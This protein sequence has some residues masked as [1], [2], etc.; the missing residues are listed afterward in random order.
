MSGFA[1]SS[2]ERKPVPSAKSHFRENAPEGRTYEA[3]TPVEIK[4]FS[5]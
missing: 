3:G 4:D 2:I 5:E 1:D